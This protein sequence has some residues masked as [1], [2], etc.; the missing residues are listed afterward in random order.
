MISVVILTFNEEVNIKKCLQSVAWTD[1]VIVIDSGSND[2]SK[3]E[4]AMNQIKILQKQYIENS[5]S[6]IKREETE[7][8]LLSIDKMDT[9]YSSRN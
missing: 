7:M 4:K 6:P 5:S 2:L 3:Q 9:V 1:D 8:T